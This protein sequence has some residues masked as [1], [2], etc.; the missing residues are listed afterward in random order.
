[1]SMPQRQSQKE[2]PI[3]LPNDQGGGFT[4]QELEIS[5][6]GV[7]VKNKYD[8]W[9]NIDR[10]T[11]LPEDALHREVDII[12]LD[13][14]ARNPDICKT[15]IAAPPM[16]YGRGRGPVNQRSYQV[17]ELAKTIL[18]LKKAFQVAKDL[19]ELYRE[20]G[21]AAAAAA[22]GGGGG[23]GK[24]TWNDKGYYFA[25]NGQYRWGDICT[26]LT[27]LAYEAR[28]IDSNEV[29]ETPCDVVNEYHEMGAYA[30]G[31]NSVCK[32]IRARKLFGWEPSHPD[33]FTLLPSILEEEAKALGL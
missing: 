4:F 27:K 3:T 12:V 18:Q 1:M 25:E 24:A 7:S 6:G 22:A 19:S 13:A 30:W 23:G 33:V 10:V 29:E 32:A 9:D 26:A 17:Y 11:S 2:C 21:E 5:P 31:S 14:S 20:L 15:A 16:I 8:D 28:Y